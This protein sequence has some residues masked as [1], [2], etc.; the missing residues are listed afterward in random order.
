VFYVRCQ[1]TFLAAVAFTLCRKSA[2][3][4]A[5]PQAELVSARLRIFEFP[6][7]CPVFLFALCRFLPGLSVALVQCITDFTEVDVGI[8]PIRISGL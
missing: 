6:S 5:A 3:Y 4:S 1:E 8:S 7:I 2:P